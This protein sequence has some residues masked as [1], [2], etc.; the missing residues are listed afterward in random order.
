HPN[1]SLDVAGDTRVEK[2]RAG[3]DE[4]R[5]VALTV[6]ARAHEGGETG[7]GTAR[8]Q[9]PFFINGDRVGAVSLKARR[10][11]EALRVQADVGGV[12]MRKGQGKKS[13]GDLGAQV[14]VVADNA[15]TTATLRTTLQRT[16]VATA[17]VR[18]PRG[19]DELS[20]NDAWQ[21][22]PVDAK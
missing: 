7:V 6:Q 8:T 21:E 12:R 15:Q 4:V 11:R 14:S 10:D 3:D 13:L 20:G 5:G 9:T 17:F 1:G 19:L 18:I 16:Q 2:L 22:I